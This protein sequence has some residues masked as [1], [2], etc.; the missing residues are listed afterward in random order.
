[1]ST[2]SWARN[3]GASLRIIAHHAVLVRVGYAWFAAFC[4]R[5]GTDLV[6]VNGDTFSPEQELA[7]DLHAI[8]NVFSA[9][10]FG[11]RS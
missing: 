4:K 6:I 11:L 1:L 5:H 8:V 7:Q 9:R 10:V 3:G 2:S